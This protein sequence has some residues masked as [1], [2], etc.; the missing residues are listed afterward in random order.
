[1]KYIILIIML[2]SVSLYPVGFKGGT[3]VSVYDYEKAN[4]SKRTPGISIGGIENFNISQSFSLNIELL[5]NVYTKSFGFTEDEGNK[6]VHYYQYTEEMFKVEIPVYAKCNVYKFINIYAGASYNIYN[7]VSETACKCIPPEDADFD[8]IHANYN[9]NKQ[10]N[11][12]G[13]IELNFDNFFI[14]LRYKHPL[15]S[16]YTN[17][18]V[19]ENQ[20]MFLISSK[21]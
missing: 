12:L 3:F 9:M 14:D 6:E 17:N 1:M 2:L 8:V 5:L 4:E 10:F 15:K 13:G 20:I 18:N 16:I 21:Y 7:G 11:I 19:F